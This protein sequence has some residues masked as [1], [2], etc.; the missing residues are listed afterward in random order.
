[1][2]QARRELEYQI[3]IIK[4]KI[5]EFICNPF[6]Y[7]QIEF[8]SKALTN[9]FLDLKFITNKYV[10]MTDP[11]ILAFIEYKNRPN[12]IYEDENKKIVRVKNIDNDIT[13]CS[14]IKSKNN[15]SLRDIVERDKLLHN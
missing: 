2:L 15:F 1:M 9:P 14:I 6:N 3:N 5:I 12:V 4:K 13:V 10:T 11:F 7:E 8:V